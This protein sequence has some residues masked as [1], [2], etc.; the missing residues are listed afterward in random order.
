MKYAAL[1]VGV[2]LV[3]AGVA[4]AIF[5]YQHASVPG[6]KN[7]IP[8][9]AFVAFT[10]LASGTQSSVRARKNYLITSQDELR[11]LWK[12]V[13][14]QGPPPTVDFS[15]QS[16][17]AVFAGEQPTAGYAIAVRRVGDSDATRVVSVE[18]ASPSTTCLLTGAPTKPYQVVKLPATALLW[19]HQDSATTTSCLR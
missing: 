18:I 1:V 5:L 10:E 13:D 8:P 19:T 2:V 17:I 9:S 15:K 11:E 6:Q 16:V 4:S 14:V 12:L 3:I 7:P